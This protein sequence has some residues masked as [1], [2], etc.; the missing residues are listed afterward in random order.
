M[1]EWLLGLGVLVVWLVLQFV[2]FP[3]LGVPS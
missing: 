2:V 3:M 1:P